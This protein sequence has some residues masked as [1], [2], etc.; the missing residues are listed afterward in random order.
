MDATKKLD[1]LAGRVDVMPTSL[2]AAIPL[3]KAG[4]ARAISIMNDERSKLMPNL[5]T[6][7]EQGIPG[8]N[9]ASWLGFSAPAGTPAAV[10][11][12]LSE[13]FAKGAKLPDVAAPLEAEGSVMI[14]STPAQ[15]RQ[16]I[17]TET[18]RWRKVGQENGIKLEE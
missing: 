16:V 17:V 8:Y 3:L 7:A 12:K 11:N 13:G 5:P 4:Q 2:V 9:Y 18:A 1:F 14:G 15:F 6:I 10:I